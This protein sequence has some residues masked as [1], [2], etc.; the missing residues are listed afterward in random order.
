MDHGGNVLARY[1][2]SR[3]AGEPLSDVRCGTTI[4]WS[5]F[6]ERLRMFWFG[7]QRG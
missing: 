7:S 3:N 5:V 2:Q 1:T 4:C 6:Q